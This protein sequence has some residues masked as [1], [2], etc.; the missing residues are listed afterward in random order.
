[1]QDAN[2]IE[3]NS[4]TTVLTFNVALSNDVQGGF[5]VAAATADGTAVA[6]TSDYVANSG[7]L[8]FAGTSGETQMFAVTLNGDTIVEADETFALILGAFS[9]IDP[10]A[11]DDISTINGTGTITNDDA[12]TLTIANLAD[13]ETD[14]GTT[15][16]TFTATLSNAVQG[17][18]DVMPNTSDGSATV[19][20]GD[21]VSVPSGPLT[22]AG[23]AGET[24]T[25]QVT[26]NGDEIVE[27]DET[28]GVG[29]NALTSIDPTAADDITLTGATGTIQNDDSATLTV[30]NVTANETNVG[31]TTFSFNVTLSHAVQ[32][33]IDVDV[34][35]SD[36]TA[37]AGVDYVGHAATL[38]SFA[39]TAG[40]V[41]TIDVMVNGNT[42]V[43]ADETFLVD[44]VIPPF[45]IGDVT[46]IA[47]TGTITNDDTA[48]LIVQDANTIETN[49]GTTLLTFNVALSNAVEGGFQ[50]A[51]ATADGT[52]VAAASDYAANT[53]TLIF[54]GTSGET[55]TFTVTLN[56]DTIVEAN[57]TLAVI[58][59]AFSAI[60]PTA[61]D[62]ITAI[63]GTGT[64]T[65][66]DTATLTIADVSA[67]ETDGGLTTF[68]FTSTL[69]N[70]VQDG[71]D[72]FPNTTD[73][74]AA[75]GSDFLLGLPSPITFVGNAGEIQTFE[76]SVFGDEVVEMDETF[77]VG[78]D[79]LM[80]IDPTAADDISLVGATGTILND[81][82][83]VLTVG[84]VTAVETDAGTTTFSFDVTLSNGVQGGLVV[85]PITT[86]VTTDGSD[87]LLPFA[88]LISFVGLA[89]EV[90]TLNIDVNGDQVV[91]LDET[92][93]VDLIIPPFWIN[94]ISATTGTGTIANDDSAALSINDVSQN[95][96]AG[97]MTFTVTLDSAVD[98]PITVI[99]N[100][101]D[102]TANSS[103]YTAGVGSLN[104]LGNAG[105]TQ[106]VTVSILEDSTVELNETFFVDLSSVTAMGRDVSISRPRGTGTIV[107]D[108]S[109]T[110]S[111]NDVSG[112]DGGIFTFTITLDQAV[113]VPVS[114]DFATSD[115]TATLLDRDYGKRLTTVN[116]SGAAGETRT[117]NVTVYNDR[118]VE[119]NEQFFVDLLQPKASGRDVSIGDGRGIGSII[120]DDTARLWI[121][122]VQRI[123]GNSGTTTFTFTVTLDAA[124]DAPVSIDFAT[125]D[126]SATLF[127]ADYVA[128]SGTLNFSGNA[129]ETKTI[130]VSVRTDS[131]LE[132][133]ET[134]Y[135]NLSGLNAG[136]RNVLIG[137]SQG[138]G[139]IIND[140]RL[141]FVARDTGKLIVDALFDHANDDLQLHVFD[142]NGNLL[143]QSLTVTDDERVIIPAVAAEAYFVTVTGPVGST[144]PFDVQFQGIPAP[145]PGGVDLIAASDTG[146]SDRDNITFD[147]TP[148]FQ[149]QADLTAC[150]TAG[151]HILSA[152]EATTGLTSGAAVRVHITNRVTGAITSGFANR[153]NSSSALFEFTPSAALP[154][155][156]YLVAAA[157]QIFDR[158]GDT[159]GNPTP[160][161]GRSQFSP[162]L[163]ITIDTTAPAAPT[164]AIDPSRTDTGVVGQPATFT[165]RITSASTTGFVGT[166][167]SPSS[168]RVFANGIAYGEA[169]VNSGGNTGDWQAPG[170]LDLNHPDLFVLDGTRLITATAQDVAGNVSAPATLE[171][172]I[173]TVGPSVSRIGIAGSPEFNLTGQ[174]ATSPT[175]RVDALALTFQDGPERSLRFQHAAVATSLL[176][177]SAFQLVGQ[178]GGVVPVSSVNIVSSTVFAGLPATRDVQL[179]FDRPLADDA[180]TLRI[181]NTLLDPAGNRLDLTESGDVLT[182]QF[183]IDSTVDLGIAGQGSVSIDLNNNFIFDPGESGEANR[184]V[185]FNLGVTTDTM[186]AG[187]F[188][189][190]SATGNNGFDRVGA[191]G[192]VN[193]V[194]R[195]LLDFN[196]D[197]LIDYRADSIWQVN[198]LPISGN[199]NAAHPGDEIGVFDGTRWYLDTN[200]DNNLGPG[201]RSFT[202]NMRGRPIV[203]DFDGDGL[204]DL[205][206]YDTSSNTF[207]FNLTTATGGVLNG[208]ANDTIQLGFSGVS[209]RPFAGDFN[210]DGIDDIGLTVPDQDGVA[211]DM[212]EWYVLVSDASQAAAGTVNALDHEFS[213]EPFGR[214][215][216]FV[217]GRGVVVPV[218]GNFVPPSAATSSTNPPTGTVNQPP[219][220]VVSG[221]W[222]SDA[223]QYTVGFSAT[224]PDG[225]AVEVTADVTTLAAY[226]DARLGL[227][228]NGNFHTNLGFRNEK[229]LRGNESRWYF[230][231]PN[232]GLY[233]WDGGNSATGSLI[234]A[235]DSTHYD[236][237]SLLYR[238]GQQRVA[239]LTT[240]TESQLT[241]AR[242]NNTQVALAVT[243]SATDGETSSSHVW[244]VDQSGEAPQ[245]PIAELPVQSVNAFPFVPDTSPP[246]P[247]VI[248]VLP[249]ARV[250]DRTPT[251]GWTADA[252][253]VRWDVSIRDV[254]N[255]VEFLRDANV[256]T[257]VFTFPQVPATTTEFRV[258]VRAFSVAGTA[259]AWSGGRNLTVTNIVPGRPRLTSSAGTIADA[260]PTITW[261]ADAN[262][263]HFDIEIT[264]AANILIFRDQQFV[265]LEFTPSTPLAEGA[266]RFGVRGIDDFNSKGGYTFAR[267]TIDVPTPAQPVLTG[268][269]SVIADASPTFRWDAVAGTFRYDLWVNNLDTGQTQV[270]RNPLI[271]TTS[272]TSSTLLPVGRYRAWL[273]AF[274]ELN[275]ASPWSAGL[276]FEVTRVAVQ[277]TT[278]LAPTSLHA[279]GQPTFFWTAVENTARYD[280]WVNNLSTGEM[281]ILRQAN[282]QTN[283]Y[284]PT[285]QLAAGD[286]RAW[287]KVFTIDGDSVWSAAHDFTILSTANVAAVETPELNVLI[288]S[289]AAEADQSMEPLHV[290]KFRESLADA[291][292]RQHDATDD[293]ARRVDVESRE[294]P[295]V[296]TLQPSSEQIM[297]LEYNSHAN[298]AHE[299]VD[300]VFKEFPVT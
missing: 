7:T 15:T 176:K 159:S 119:L 189:P 40:E 293:A 141:R 222:T 17:G 173:D 188:R 138:L 96:A 74:S 54:A 114:V 21:F 271:K 198:G 258:W 11:A 19:A 124:V 44:L 35:T 205:A 250:G 297:D 263:T 224:D 238:A 254:T 128:N 6:A 195:W 153:L 87:Y 249:G 190:A 92:F 58:L 59:G 122:D 4:G 78:F 133:D 240:L 273:K 34:N 121:N 41:Q 272:H 62:D 184:D 285:E 112:S 70:A 65:N 267:F 98:A 300:Q 286:Y 107:N 144:N 161:T 100:T 22:F 37:I 217:F 38:L 213:P 152:G 245:L 125:A 165:D 28:F 264:D 197:G 172:M 81:D 148:T 120:N 157:V 255:G 261:T 196:D 94:D 47:G 226:W 235:F 135:V 101:A 193:N 99:F 131:T 134:F 234:A 49:L 202:G 283:W 246:A 117:V 215:R 219:V 177:P 102:G 175:P 72:F 253:A 180:Y 48:T 36:V 8:I 79:P 105:E 251:I 209:E 136:G 214:D 279:N 56:G 132:L 248:N 203:G 108:D 23:G 111:V 95:E 130:D 221:P 270:I 244:I 163:Q 158:Q 278:L 275:E 61:A 289:L 211:A 183:T 260:T 295:S 60:D 200:G 50:I 259:S 127:N 151:I 32:G 162:S 187:Q 227:H 192:R 76:V 93:L 1:M 182:F 57:E 169:S 299:L 26:V 191:Y 284:L 201:D 33:G 113:D 3:T 71:F 43:E 116:L 55:Q 276:D 228:T 91:E 155:G 290:E 291:S 174:T 88:S 77:G 66:D 294:Y 225:D 75:N 42:V 20:D 53:G 69:S 168:I 97:N 25:F 126:G 179:R 239:A 164:L 51:A 257:N 109:A 231:T 63:N 24:Q 199:F 236:D 106:L 298:S 232:G 68:T 206:T 145:V 29:F 167:E 265:G 146:I 115:D 137:D 30:S 166:A 274:N 5:Q 154:Q 281:Q 171:I 16:F 89:G 73:G 262:A 27:L 170:Q 185:T 84:N 118:K 67:L 204:D 104:F 266:Y 288:A 45:W 287:V 247:P 230:V 14:A 12:A 233:A 110:L 292:S 186:F 86:D 82:S 83:A 139:V 123:E 156:Q 10:T 147:T 243:I 212:A 90:Q 181:S 150:E 218:V 129:R 194:F 85:S 220:L 13:L 210:L 277:P 39:G 140:D 269:A 9:A 268:P 142:R 237:P 143:G 252:K 282:L 223:V 160:A 280:L 46:A 80:N 296:R 241:V 256:A 229:W 242:T 52:A 216:L 31:T 208:N 103:D 149:I 178:S 207:Q 64:I 18:F 2:T